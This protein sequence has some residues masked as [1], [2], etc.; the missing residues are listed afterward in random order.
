MTAAHWSYD[1]RP[2]ARFALRDTEVVGLPDNLGLDA[3]RLV[4]MME[5]LRKLALLG[6]PRRPQT[7]DE[8]FLAAYG[9]SGRPGSD[10]P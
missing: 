9:R 1:G 4:L 2:V 3:Q 8:I 7:P 6:W 5:R 10:R